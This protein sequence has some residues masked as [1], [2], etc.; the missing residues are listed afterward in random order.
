MDSN[1]GAFSSYS[2]DAGKYRLNVSASDGR[3]T[4]YGIIE[5]N[6]ISITDEMLSDAVGIQIESI[7]SVEFVALHRRAFERALRT[8]IPDVR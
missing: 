8:I 4:R 7:T 3:F 2:L 6:V 5:V 1:T